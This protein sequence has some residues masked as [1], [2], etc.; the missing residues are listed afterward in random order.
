MRTLTKLSPFIA[1]LWLTGCPQTADV[2]TPDGGL[3]DARSTSPEDT[4][5]TCSDDLDN[6]GDGSTDCN[7][8]DCALFVFCQSLDAGHPDTGLVETAD[9]GT[10]AKDAGQEGACSVDP[11]SAVDF[12]AVATGTS[13]TRQLKV[14]NQTSQ[15]IALTVT[16]ISGLDALSFFLPNFAPGTITVPAAGSISIPVQ[17]A[18]TR[19][20]V[21]SAQLAF[22]VPNA[23]GLTTIALTGAG[24]GQ[25]LDCA[26]KV[27]VRDPA[28][29]HEKWVCQADFGYVHPAGRQVA[30]VR[31]VNVGSSSIDVS[32]FALTQPASGGVF[33]FESPPPATA[34]LAPN[35]G[36]V[37]LSLSFAPSQPGT[38]TGRLGFTSTDPKVP[39][40]SFV[41]QGVGAGPVISVTPAALDFHQVSLEGSLTSRL[42]IANQG[43]DMQGTTADNLILAAPVAGTLCAASADCPLA[44]QTCAAST[45]WEAKTLEIV[46]DAAYEFRVSSIPMFGADGLPAGESADLQVAFNPKS[47]GPRS[48]TLRIYSNDPATPV[49]EIPLVGEGVDAP[50]CDLEVVPAQLQ[51]GSV[52]PGRSLELLAFHSQRLGEPRLYALLQQLRPWE[53]RRSSRCPTA[54][55]PT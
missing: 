20:G 33:A 42:T 19:L 10:P 46:G 50:P 22:T 9:S 17:F 27:L 30:K 6:D 29:G 44:G 49:T 39:A 35:G 55:S 15:A 13:L 32:S 48:A 4:A 28:T 16:P 54:R 7:D 3:P 45:C 51:F 43:S 2:R 14:S 23:C 8:P 40:G 34:T 12:G 18:P 24:I 5:S 21:H 26:P 36:A 38:H 52:E 37:E 11:G 41:L 31:L 25:S 47:A 53:A 1:A